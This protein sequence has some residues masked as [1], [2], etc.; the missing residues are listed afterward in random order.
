MRVGLVHATTDNKTYTYN[1]IVYVDIV[2][3]CVTRDSV[4]GSNVR[5]VT[6][7]KQMVTTSTVWWTSVQ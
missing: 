1:G 3:V 5:S 4:H 6:N 7:G 2:S